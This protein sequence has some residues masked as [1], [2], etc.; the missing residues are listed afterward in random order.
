MEPLPDLIACVR[1]VVGLTHRSVVAPSEPT[2][3]APASG[4]AADEECI[5]VSCGLVHGMQLH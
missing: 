3:P 1:A 5:R 4:A 2:S